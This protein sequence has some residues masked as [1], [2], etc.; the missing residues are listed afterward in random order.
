MGN[1]QPACWTSERRCSACRGGRLPECRCARSLCCW[2]CRRGSNRRELC[3]RFGIAPKT[4]YKWLMRYAQEGASGLEDRSKRPRR[5]PARTVA[6]VE[7][8]VIRLRRE[9]RKSWGGGKLAR[10][11]KSRGGPALA[12]S[13]VTA[14]ATPSATPSLPPALR[15]HGVAAPA[16]DRANLHVHSPGTDAT[17]CSHCCGLFPTLRTAGSSPS[18]PP[19]PPTR[20][21]PALA[22]YRSPAMASRSPPRHDQSNLS[23]I[24]PVYSVLD[25]SGLY[26][27]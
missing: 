6:E 25:P 4:G 23:S 3:R 1:T 17:T 5:S 8:D 12:P 9:S 22:P 16:N 24:Y 2:R 26:P 20:N 13:T 11:L 15:A 10:L 14:S 21:S 18:R 7:Q 27:F 19:K